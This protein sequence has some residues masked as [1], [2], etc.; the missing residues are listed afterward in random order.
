MSTTK[1]LHSE[2]KVK[3]SGLWTFVGL[4]WAV[5]AQA[6][7]PYIDEVKALGAVAGQGMACGASKYNTFELLARAILI[8][9]APSDKIQS[10]GVY[11]YNEAKANAYISK[12]MDGFFECGA[13]N[14]RFDN[15]DIF[16]ATLYRDGTIK[17]PDGTIITP[18]RAYDATLVYNKDMDV[19]AEEIYSGGGNQD[20]GEIRIKTEGS[21]SEVRAVYQPASSAEEVSALVSVSEPDAQTYA[22]PQEDSGIGHIKSRWKN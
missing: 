22:E 6:Q 21:S 8:S 3:Y 4:F 20:V 11:A 13:I 7:M 5:S 17:M 1:L 16:K 15:Q 19:D 10:E 9:K 18:R 14:R 2:E 12:Q